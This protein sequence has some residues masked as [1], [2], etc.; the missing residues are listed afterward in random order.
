[1]ALGELQATLE[2]NRWEEEQLG[3][4]LRHYLQ[5]RD[6]CPLLPMPQMRIGFY[7]SSLAKADPRR[8]YFDR[9]KFLVPADAEL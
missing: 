6:R 9:A 4:A 3:A 7:A 1:M 5:A 8:A 2:R